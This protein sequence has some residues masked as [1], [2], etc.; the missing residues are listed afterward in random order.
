MLTSEKRSDYEIIYDDSGESEYYGEPNWF[1][2]DQLGNVLHDL[3]FETQQEARDYLE[4]CD[5]EDL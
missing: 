2:S 4:S 1:I 3:S 5:E